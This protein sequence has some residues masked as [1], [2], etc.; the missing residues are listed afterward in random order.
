MIVAE[1]V[2]N[3]KRRQFTAHELA[4]VI[5]K[6]ES[7]FCERK[8]KRTGKTEKVL[9][10]Q[11]MSE[12]GAQYPKMINFDVGQTSTRPFRYFYEK[13]PKFVPQVEPAKETAKEA[14]KEPAQKTATVKPAKAPAKKAAKKT[15]KKTAKKAVKKVSKKK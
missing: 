1:I 15:V 10:F 14:A 4:E 3:N 13:K 7:E 5:M 11:L 9:L 8:M 12:I 6:T 2:A